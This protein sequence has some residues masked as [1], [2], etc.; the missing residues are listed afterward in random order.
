MSLG[1]Q[2]CGVSLPKI[3]LTDRT[4]AIH[5]RKRLRHKDGRYIDVLDRGLTI[6]N[7]RAQIRRIVGSVVD[8]TE[9]KRAEA[10]LRGSETA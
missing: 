9:R 3:G 1:G 4:L 5:R 10:L 7:E 8:I 6:H 2:N